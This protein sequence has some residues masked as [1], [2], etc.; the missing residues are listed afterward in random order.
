MRDE[1]LNGEIFYSIKEQR[2][3]ADSRR[4]HYNTTRLNSSLGYKPPASADGR[5][6]TL[7]SKESQSLHSPC[8][9]ILDRPEPKDRCDK[10]TSSGTK[11]RSG[12]C[13]QSKVAF[14]HSCPPSLIAAN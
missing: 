10:I 13:Y 14:I 9:H 1:F 8:Y 2:V 5:Y 12:H 4:K 3:L 7:G 6:R 11:H